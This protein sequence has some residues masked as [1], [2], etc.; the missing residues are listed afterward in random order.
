MF[1]V[2]AYHVKLFVSSQKLLIYTAKMSEKGKEKAPSRH[3]TPVER[4]FFLQ[5]LL[6]FKDVVENKKATHAH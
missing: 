6:Q 3:Y 1:T 2:S 4:E 5:L